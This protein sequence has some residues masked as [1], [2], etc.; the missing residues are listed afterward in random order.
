[1]IVYIDTE[2]PQKSYLRYNLLSVF[3]LGIAHNIYDRLI[4]EAQKRDNLIK[5]TRGGK[6]IPFN[7]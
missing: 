2:K 7:S 5:I 4:I 3:E 1:M 6:K